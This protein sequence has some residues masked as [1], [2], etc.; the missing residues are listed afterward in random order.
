MDVLSTIIANT[1][2]DGQRLYYPQ[3]KCVTPLM[4]SQLKQTGLRVCLISLSLPLPRFPSPSLPLPLPPSPSPSLPLPSSL[5]LHPSPSLS[6]TLSPCP[7]QLV[8]DA[9]FYSESESEEEEDRSQTSSKSSGHGK[10]GP[11]KKPYTMDP[12]H[13][14]L[15]RNCKP[16]LQSRNASVSHVIVTWI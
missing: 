3:P 13:R 6:L 9:P 12:D 5:S 8:E 2:G 10:A 14:L 16:L 11:K 15:L 1:V 7:S 4:S